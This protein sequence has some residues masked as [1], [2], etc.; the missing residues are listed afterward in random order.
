MYARLDD[1]AAFRGRPKHVKASARDDEDATSVVMPM[2]MG[3]CKEHVQELRRNRREIAADSLAERDDGV[4][5]SNVSR[6]L[7]RNV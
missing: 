6:C 3:R 5:P 7:H 2:V 4:R 1:Q